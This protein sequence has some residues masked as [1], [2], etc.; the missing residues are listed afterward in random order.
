MSSTTNTNSTSSSDPLLDP[1]QPKP[2]CSSTNQ[3]YD[4]Q[5]RVCVSCRDPTVK[6]LVNS[7]SGKS[8]TP[9][10]NSVEGNI[11]YQCKNNPIVSK[12]TTGSILSQTCDSGETLINGKCV[13]TF[14]AKQK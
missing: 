3:L 7:N 11:S 4:S 5:F 6:P 9:D 2:L 1:N 10:N 14:N 8:S 12:D 13:I